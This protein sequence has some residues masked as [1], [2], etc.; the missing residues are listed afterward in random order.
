M[1]VI[2]GIQQIEA[3]KTI[4]FGF[5]AN[6]FLIE[7]D[8]L[9]LIDTGLPGNKEKILSYITKT[10]GQDPHDIHTIILTHY[11]LDHIGNVIELQQATGA[12]VAIHTA[13][14]KHLSEE[15]QGALP[16][17]V[18]KQKHGETI[19]FTPDTLLNDGDMIAGLQCIHV[20]GH[21]PGNIAVLDP[22]R[23][24]LFCGDTMFGVDGK[25]SIPQ[26]IQER[27]KTMG[28]W[29]IAIESIRKLTQCDVN[30]L[31]FGH[32]DPIIHNAHDCMTEFIRKF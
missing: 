30:S 31:F 13:D 11:H 14:A 7:Q 5:Y 23:K 28:T 21:T 9:I 22:N 6:C 32:G 29:E 2:Q 3:G 18:D 26:G 12:K 25:I 27:M 15:I 19:T 16:S 24:A 1:K 4:D 10:A 17:K 20:P 8:G